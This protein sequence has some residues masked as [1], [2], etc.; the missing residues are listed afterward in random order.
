MPHEVDEWRKKHQMSVSGRNPPNPIQTFE[1]ANF[2]EYI[3]K[4]IRK[5]GFTAPSAIQSQAWP[6]ALSGRDVIGIAKTGSGKTLAFLL[7]SMLH[8]KA[9]PPLKRGD[10][11][12]ALVLS[13]TRELAVQTK[14]E[15]DRF[16]H[17]SGIRAVCVYGGAPKREQAWPLQNGVEIVIATP[18]RLID[19]LE[20]R[21]TNLKRITYLVLDEAD[22]MLDMGF[23]PQIR[24][25]VGQI[26]NDRQT[27][28]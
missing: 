27:L 15:V 23:E 13:P 16:S 4:E 28:L 11:P 5:A 19:F 26:R 17:S 3:M 20:N 18:G 10:G 21:T 22:R 14:E 6:M 12:V 24:T 8:I 7:P 2:P 1:H 9:Q 25:I